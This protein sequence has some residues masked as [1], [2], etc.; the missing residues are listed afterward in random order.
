MSV[1][2]RLATSRAEAFCSISEQAHVREA[3]NPPQ[4][5][6]QDVDRDFGH[7]SDDQEKYEA[8]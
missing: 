1:P 8:G 4:L 3:S 2:R 7:S 5:D 6:I